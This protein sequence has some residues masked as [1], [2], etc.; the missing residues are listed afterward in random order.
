MRCRA[1]PIDAAMRTLF[2]L[3]RMRITPMPMMPLRALLSD[4]CRRAYASC[5]SVIRYAARQARH[6]MR[7]WRHSAASF[8]AMMLICAKMF[9]YSC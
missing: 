5:S 2:R 3:R 9:K 1:L 7:I 4:A 6:A 8:I